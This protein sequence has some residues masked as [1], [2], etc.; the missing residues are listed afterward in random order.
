MSQS[1]A[2]CERLRFVEWQGKGSPLRW[3]I[4]DN[5]VRR[6]LTSS[7]KAVLA[8]ELLPGVKSGDIHIIRTML[9]F[10]STFLRL[11]GTAKHLFEPSNEYLVS[12]R[13][14]KRVVSVIEEHLLT[15]GFRAG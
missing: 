12:E 15:C 14:T 13:V 5:M 1:P 2:A 11:E 9:R 4:S 3:V 8:L 10:R 6:H 7:Q